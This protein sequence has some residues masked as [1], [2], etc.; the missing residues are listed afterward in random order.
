MLIDLYISITIYAEKCKDFLWQSVG[1]SVHPANTDV[2]CVHS[3]YVFVG[4]FDDQCAV[5]VDI[6]GAAVPGFVRFDKRNLF[7]HSDAV[8]AVGV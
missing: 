4:E 8:P 2:S 5:I 1:I 6:Q 3:F 7:S